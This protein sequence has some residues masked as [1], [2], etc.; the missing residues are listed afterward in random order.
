[1]A[2][3]QCGQLDT[4]KIK[5][6]VGS[7]QEGVGPLAREGCKDCIYLPGS[8]GIEDSDLHSENGSSCFD[9]LRNG[10]GA[11]SIR[12]IDEHGDA[13]C[14]GFTQQSQ[15]HPLGGG[16]DVGAVHGRRSGA[17]AYSRPISARPGPVLR[18]SHQVEERHQA[19]D[20]PSHPKICF[21]VS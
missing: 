5:E 16:F 13:N 2:R 7:D 20:Y 8:A 21:P 19:E 18:N 12:G 15:L 3:R 14:S 10:L 11:R 6:W 4:P 17:S 1:M 9:I